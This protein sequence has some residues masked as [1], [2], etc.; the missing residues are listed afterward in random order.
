VRALTVACLITLGLSAAA[1]APNAH[2]SV[3]FELVN[4]HVYLEVVLNG[5]GPYHFV[6]DSGGSNMIDPAVAADLGVTVGKRRRIV[7]VGNTSEASGATFVEHVGIGE[8][9]LEQQNFIVAQTRATIGPAEGLPIDGLVGRELLERFV[10]TVDYARRELRLKEPSASDEPPS[11]GTTLPLDID[12]GLPHV[13]CQIARVSGR[14]TVDTGSRLSLSVLR[15]FAALHPDVAPKH[16]SAVGIDGFGFG[17]AAYGRLGRVADLRFGNLVI[18]DSIADFS[19]QRAGAFDDPKV[20]ANVGGGV[21]RR[22]TL[23]FEYARKRLTLEPNADFARPDAFDRS[24]LFLTAEAGGVHVVG[25]RPGTPALEAGLSSGER[26]ISIDGQ[27]ISAEDLGRVRERLFGLPGASV[28]LG[29]QSA[30][31]TQ[32]EVTLVLRDY[33]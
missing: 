18:H 9:G 15:P 8:I 21:W 7:G 5:K 4:N 22:F 3:P 13:P 1:P 11:G 29:V 31:G 33:V 20:A 25:V 17:G 30:D 32:R 10:V 12:E 6:F 2:I 23:T 19:T 24:G 16:L 14:C 26:L 28:R 27:P